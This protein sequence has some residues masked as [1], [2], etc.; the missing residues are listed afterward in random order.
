MIRVIYEI[1]RT[2]DENKSEIV[3]KTQDLYHCRLYLNPFTFT[4]IC[5]KRCD[6]IYCDSRFMDDLSGR[7]II[8]SV[9]KP[10]LCLKHP[11][12]EGFRIFDI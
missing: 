2:N 8:D 4:G 9:F 7:E 6:T 12:G 1:I 3:E 11:D 10:M 5:G